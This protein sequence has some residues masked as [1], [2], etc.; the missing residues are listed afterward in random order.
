MNPGSCG[1]MAAWAGERSVAQSCTGRSRRHPRARMKVS[2]L[3]ACLRPGR[4]LG[5]RCAQ[6]VSLWH[7]RW[8]RQLGQKPNKWSNVPLQYQHTD[9]CC[10]AAR[11]PLPRASAE[12]FD[13][14]NGITI[15]KQ[16]VHKTKVIYIGRDKTQNPACDDYFYA[17][18]PS[19]TINTKHTPQEPRTWHPRL[20]RASTSV[21]TNGGNAVV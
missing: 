13:H 1:Q 5:P 17:I 6:E 21:R 2:H 3:S 9:I 19:S 7:R 12:E 15:C 4:H 8:Q 18:H 10:S 11:A 16:A 14:D 20:S